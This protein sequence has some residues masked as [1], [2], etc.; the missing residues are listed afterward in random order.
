MTGLY[1]DSLR[2]RRG[3]V[4][5][6]TY[7]MV[8][9]PKY[10]WKVISARVMQTLMGSLS[11][12]CRLKEWILKEANGEMDHVHILVELPPTVCVADAVR[13]L[14]TNSSRMVRAMRFHE[15]TQRLWSGSFWSPSYFA[16]TCGVRH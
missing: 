7:H 13:L 16:V 3:S 12:T 14:K 2:R 6:L 4:T 9:T 8:F 1:R 11:E 10:R 15:V 5:A